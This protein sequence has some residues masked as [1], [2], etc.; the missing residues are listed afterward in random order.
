MQQIIFRQ[1]IAT[2]YNDYKSVRLESLKQYPN[3]FGTTYDEELNST[4]LKLD[5]AIKCADNNNFAFGAFSSAEKLIGI[6]G[7]VTEPRLKTKHR[8]EVVH[9]FVDSKYAGQGIGRALLQLVIN[10]AFDNSQ[11]EQIILS[12][13]YTNKNALNL[14]KQLRFAEYGRLEKYFKTKDQYYTQSFLCLRRKG[15]E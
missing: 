6:C 7:F 10:K 13:V 4:S 15:S 14:Y 12:V 9:M 5:T 11:I 3:N 8:G 2:D 1:L